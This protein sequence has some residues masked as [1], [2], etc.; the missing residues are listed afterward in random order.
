[1]DRYFI[2]LRNDKDENLDFLVI[3]IEPEPEEDQSFPDQ[4]F[5]HVQTK[6]LYSLKEIWDQN[7]DGGD[8]STQPNLFKNKLIDHFKQIDYDYD[9]NWILDYP[10]Q[11]GDK[12]WRSWELKQ[13]FEIYEL[14]SPTGTKLD[15]NLYFSFPKLDDSEEVKMI[16]KYYF[17]PGICES[18]SLKELFLANQDIKIDL[19]L[20]ETEEKVGTLQVS[21]SL[22]WQKLVFILSQ[23]K[24]LDVSKTNGDEICPL[25]QEEFENPY[26]LSLN[27]RTYS[28][29]PF[30]EAVEAIL[31]QGNPLR[32]EDVTLL[33][34]MLTNLKFYPHKTRGTKG[35]I[36]TF[37][38]NQIKLLPYD[39]LLIKKE[40]IKEIS[41][42]LKN[43]PKREIWDYKG[44]WSLYAGKRGYNQK[45][46]GIGVSISNLKIKDQ[47]FPPPNSHPKC[48]SG[49]IT[50]K[51]IYF[52]NC[53]IDLSSCWCGLDIKTSLFEDCIFLISKNNI[54][55]H[56]QIIMSNQINCQ[57]I[58]QK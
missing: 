29:T 42:F 23:Y 41:S 25:S 6:R 2:N 57:K 13:V 14:K 53:I 19:I 9:Y 16:E 10:I 50:F 33:P 21:P 11:V 34:E 56:G 1:M 55:H 36:I 26:I 3:K 40:N 7:K 20:K 30:M 37:N 38:K 51:N 35:E 52:K 47:T 43:M 39:G 54:G 24:M 45:W 46:P 27:G 8:W 5:Y 18:Y 17:F 12:T 58:K 48:D 22:I 15:T 44:L 32:L 49:H 28:L 4:L 31:F